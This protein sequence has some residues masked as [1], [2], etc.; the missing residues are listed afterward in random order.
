MPA[1]Q[2][3]V[4]DYGDTLI[5][6]EYDQAAHVRSLGLL[7]DHLGS[8]DV[9]AERL[10]E[11]VDARLGEALEARGDDG[12]LDFALVV[13]ESL[14]AVDVGADPDAVIAAMRAGQRAWESQRALHPDAVEL[15]R[16]VRALGPAHRPRVEHLRPGG[17]DGRGPGAAGPRRSDRRGRVLVGSG[18]PQAA[19]R[20]LP[21]ALEGSA[22][23]RA[24]RCSSATG[25]GRTSRPGRGRHGDVPGHL[26]SQRRGR[27]LP[28]DPCRETP[29]R[30]PPLT[31]ASGH[32]GRLVAVMGWIRQRLP[33]AR[34]RDRWSAAAAASS[35]RK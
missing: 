10:F 31:R 4:F 20:Y 23:S 35:A 29:G 25:C 18:H 28:A 7:L 14:A 9:P 6:F 17:A 1:F 19:S 12:E 13:R 11:E 2:G 34:T 5:R 32:T 16:G 8:G 22:Q 33:M 15:L 30:A 21:D 27:P 3:A 24:A 26:V